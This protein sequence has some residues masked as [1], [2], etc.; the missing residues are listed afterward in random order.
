MTGSFRRTKSGRWEVFL[1]IEGSRKTATFGSK[2][3]CQ[4]WVA[5]QTHKGLGNY[6][7]RLE[8]LAKRYA[9][10]VSPKK[11][12]G[13]WE[14]IRLNALS[15]SFPKL[16]NKRL[17]NI[18]REDLEAMIAVR[19]ESVSN[20]TIN[21]ELNLLSAVFTQGRRWRMMT[22]KPTA[23]LVRPKDPPHRDRRISEVE[24]EM[25]LHALSYSEEAP[26]SM[27]RQRVAI[28]FL[29]AI[30]TAMRQGELCQVPW[31]DVRL[32]ERFI[33]I[34][35]SI[36]KTGV[37]REV[38]L[39]AEAVRL[40][41]R[42][43]KRG[44]LM[45]GVTAG[46]VSTIFRKAVS[47]AGIDNLKFHDSRHEATTRL[48]QRLMVLDLARVTGHRDIRQLMTYYNKNARELADLL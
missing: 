16:F 41:N 27:Q 23:D 28:A 2:R 20:S 1:M 10:E 40:I 11:K 39:S 17:D 30:E 3:E 21:R 15:E 38:P 35:H 45:L 5:E 22:G 9:E 14:V 46:T 8:D 31:K 32:D 37:G 29:L 7:W 33:R 36:T 44:S 13:R 48:A 42:I 25:I 43:P 18:S 19:S 34:D 26:I 47:D 6:K 12:G 4:M 24:I